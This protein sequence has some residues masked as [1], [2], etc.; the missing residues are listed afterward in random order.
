[1]AGGENSFGAGG[2]LRSSL[3]DALP[4]YMDVRARELSA[5]LALVLAV[6]KSGSMGRCHC[7]NPDLN[8]TYT[9]QEVGQPKVDIAKEAIMRA[10]SALSEQDILGVVAF[11][12]EARWAVEAS[13]L[14]NLVTLEQSIGGIQAFG[15]TNVG[16]GVEAAYSALQDSEARRKHIIL[17]TD[18]WTHSGDLTGLARR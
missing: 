6:D 9:R 8:Q 16:A 10:A 4:V 12:D 1:M 5:N 7:D 18:G 14:T 13:R 2:Y 17:L 15:Q 11:D 3:E